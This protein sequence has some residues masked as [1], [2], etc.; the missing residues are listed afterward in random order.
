MNAKQRRARKLA[1]LASV[2]ASGGTL[3]TT[4]E[5]RWRDAFVDASKIVFFQFFD[6][7]TPDADD[8]FADPGRQFGGGL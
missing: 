8:I 4:C 6:N 2:L 1:L 5:S 3:F 7:L